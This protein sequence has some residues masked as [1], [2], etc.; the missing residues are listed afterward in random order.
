MQPVFGTSLNFE[1]KSAD[2]EVIWVKIVSVFSVT[3]TIS[4]QII[5]S[6]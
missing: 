3:N 5:H 2:P 6:I 1:T 4:F